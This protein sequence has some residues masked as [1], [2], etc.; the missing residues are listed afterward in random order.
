MN[1]L[2]REASLSPGLTC[3]PGD[4]IKKIPMARNETNGFLKL[5]I[6]KW[7]SKIP[8]F[9]ARNWFFIQI[10]HVVLDISTMECFSVN[11]TSK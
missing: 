6:L 5:A 2:A 1:N 10:L 7:I 9:L 8:G 4:G 3:H 11:V